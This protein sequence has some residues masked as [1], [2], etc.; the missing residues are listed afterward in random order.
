QHPRGREGRKPQVEPRWRGRAGG[1]QAGVEH[2]PRRQESRAPHEERRQALD[3]KTD[4]EVGRTPDQIDRCERGDHQAARRLASTVSIHVSSSRE[5]KFNGTG[6]NKGNKAQGFRCSIDEV[7]SC[8]VELSQPVSTSFSLV[9]SV[10]RFP[11]QVH[12]ASSNGSSMRE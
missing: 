11:F 1:A 12:W 9:P 3:G 4:A 10:K 7:V 6:E 8:D 2:E 5:Q